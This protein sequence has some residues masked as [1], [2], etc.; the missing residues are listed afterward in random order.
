[1]WRELRPRT[2]GPESHTEAR[3]TAGMVRPMLAM[4]EPSARFRLVCTRSRRAERTAAMVSGSRTSSPRLV[5]AVREDG[6]WAC[7]SAVI[8]SP[9]R[10]IGRK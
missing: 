4:A 9:W 3:A 6:A 10:V 8:T 5:R 2:S 7:S 1:M